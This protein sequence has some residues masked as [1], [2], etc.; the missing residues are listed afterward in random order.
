MNKVFAVL[1]LWIAGGSS[2]S[3][4]GEKDPGSADNLE[5]NEGD[6]KGGATESTAEGTAER[7]PETVKDA[8]V[9]AN[10]EEY[11]AYECTTQGQVECSVSV[12]E[13]CVDDCMLLHDFFASVGC[14]AALGTWDRC[15]QTKGTDVWYCDETKGVML[16]DGACAE[17]ASAFFACSQ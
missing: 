4:A 13:S 10:A 6:A 8:G 3:C 2:C 7:E 17:E 14:G 11:C 16:E 15:L 9:A 12:S 1:S 5:A